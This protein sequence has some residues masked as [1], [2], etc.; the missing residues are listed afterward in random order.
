M[1]TSQTLERL[2]SIGLDSETIGDI[3]ADLG[4]L[5]EALEIIDRALLQFASGDDVQEAVE[6]IESEVRDHIPGHVRS[7]RRLPGRLRRSVQRRT[8]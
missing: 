4:D 3:A 8:A 2:A 7:L 1:A 5:R 6:A